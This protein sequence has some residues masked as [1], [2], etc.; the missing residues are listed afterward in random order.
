MSP[1]RLAE[2]AAAGAPRAQPAAA[3]PGN[4]EGFYQGVREPLPLDPA[5]RFVRERVEFIQG[6]EEF[7]AERILV[8]EQQKPGTN[9]TH[10]CHE[11]S[12]CRRAVF[13]IPLLTGNSTRGC[14]VGQ[15]GPRTRPSSGM[16][17]TGFSC[18]ITCPSQR[19]IDCRLVSSSLVASSRCVSSAR[20]PS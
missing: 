15:R 3:P 20:A 13:F 1:R 4:Q 11:K 8:D 19:Y 17:S 14:P 5:M 12:A 2:M 7:W 16:L 6:E 9:R 10:Q 18:T